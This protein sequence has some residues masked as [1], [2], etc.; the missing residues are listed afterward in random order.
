[1]KEERFPHTRKPLRGWRLRVAEGGS[2]GTTKEGTATGV[3]RAKRR[4]SC[5]EDQSQAALTS[6]RG[7]S[8]HP[9][10]RARLGAEAP[11]SVG[12]QGEDWGW[13]C[14]HSLRGLAYHN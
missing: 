2:F 13:L 5:T 7:L 6:L 12:L 11:A 3:R 9:P 14:E 10:G 4:D 8:G 1:M